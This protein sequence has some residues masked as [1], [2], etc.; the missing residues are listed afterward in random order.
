MDECK[1]QEQQEEEEKNI[2]IVRNHFEQIEKGYTQ[3]RKKGCLARWYHYNT[4]NSQITLAIANASMLLLLEKKKTKKK[5][6]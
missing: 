5:N 4:L 3:D 2:V 6:E 1:E